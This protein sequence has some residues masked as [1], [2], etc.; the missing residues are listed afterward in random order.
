MNI[1]PSEAFIPYSKHISTVKRT[2]KWILLHRKYS[3]LPSSITGFQLWFEL[4][5]SQTHV[6]IMC[7]I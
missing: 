2:E 5:L 1:T 7:H 6:C 4:Y 3:H